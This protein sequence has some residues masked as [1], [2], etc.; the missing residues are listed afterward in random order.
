MET[1][2]TEILCEQQVVDLTCDEGTRIHISEV[3]FGKK[4]D[5]LSLDTTLS[6][7]ANNMRE[8]V[9]LLCNSHNTCHINNSLNN[10]TGFLSPVPRKVGFT[11]RCEFEYY[12]CFADKSNFDLHDHGFLHRANMS[13]KICYHECSKENVTR[14]YF[15]TE[16][17]SHC[18]CGGIIGLSTL[19]QRKQKENKCETPCMSNENEMCGSRNRASVYVVNTDKQQIDLT[20]ITQMNLHSC[21]YGSGMKDI[22]IKSLEKSEYCNDLTDSAFPY[23]RDI[24]DDSR[25]LKKYMKISYSCLEESNHPIG[26]VHSINGITSSYNSNTIKSVSVGPFYSI[27]AR[28]VG[29]VIG[30]VILVVFLTLCLCKNK[31][32]KKNG[33]PYTTTTNGSEI[34]DKA[35]L[36]MLSSNNPSSPGYVSLQL[37][38]TEFFEYAQTM[39]TDEQDLTDDEIIND[40]CSKQSANA[41]GVNHYESVEA[42][43]YSQFEKNS[44]CNQFLNPSES[45]FNKSQVN[46]RNKIEGLL[47]GRNIICEATIDNPYDTID[48]EETGFSRSKYNDSTSK[49]YKIIH[50]EYPTQMECT[51]N[52]YAILDPKETGF[53]RSNYYKSDIQLE[54]NVHGEAPTQRECTC[55]AYGVLDPKETGFY[56]S[57]S[58]NSN[59]K[60]DQ[61]FNGEDLN[62]RKS[63]GDAYAVLDP[64]ETGFYR[65][66]SYN[67]KS[68][69]EKKSQSED[70]T[71]W[72][73]IANSY[74]EL[75]P[76]ET[77]FYKSHSLGNELEKVFPGDDLNHK[78]QSTFDTYP[79]P[80]LEETGYNR[81]EL[82][83]YKHGCSEK[84]RKDHQSISVDNRIEDFTQNAYSVLDSS[85]T[86]FI[87]G[88]VT[89]PMNEACQTNNENDLY[90]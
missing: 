54:K 50:G 84:T 70:R 79:I 61:I 87:R 18:V 31:S 58:Y 42:A 56:R 74:A 33:R 64:K 2:L 39:V 63:T 15:A 4:E 19:K 86:G 77:G 76:K 3:N 59:S 30:A 25:Y 49:S 78:Y 23:T 28:I 80:N 34:Q 24:S 44:P 36:V 27:N 35:L 22:N 41:N 85:E 12:G 47:S 45:V 8:I 9:R 66:I 72:D 65:S 62:Q 20:Y 40:H 16:D 46:S 71:H 81:S 32:R 55:N 69:L 53:Y 43:N 67:S 1:N 90:T 21:K 51:G 57:N 17:G 88:Q 37:N 73:G 89:V 29:G 82:D 7:N 48:T 10:F 5:D 38:H 75:D 60:L 68:K 14:Q 6:R 26:S 13:A 11:Y 83:N 52:A